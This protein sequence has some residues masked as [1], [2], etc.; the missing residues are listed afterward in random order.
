MSRPQ[1]SSKPPPLWINSE[2]CRSGWKQTSPLNKLAASSRLVSV[3]G[4]TLPL[5]TTSQEAKVPE[6]INR[7]PLTK[8]V[9]LL[10]FF[11]FKLKDLSWLSV[12]KLVLYRQAYVSMWHLIGIYLTINSIIKYSYT[13][14]NLELI[15]N[16][17]NIT[18]RGQTK[19]VNE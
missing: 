3:R 17:F 16:Y 13:E 12:L 9:P 15:R 7:K 4:S 2:L 18:R 11:R 10:Y 14:L 5:H 6:Q 19:L 8:N 1:V